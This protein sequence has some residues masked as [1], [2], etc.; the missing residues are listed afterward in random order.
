MWSV[1]K[2]LSKCS[3]ASNRLATSM[4]GTTPC[5]LISPHRSCNAE[6]I[7][8][9]LEDLAIQAEPIPCLSVS[10]LFP[11]IEPIVEK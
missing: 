4:V 11:F 2:Y 7:G 3:F 8:N 10:T 1:G 5:A 9:G 6:V